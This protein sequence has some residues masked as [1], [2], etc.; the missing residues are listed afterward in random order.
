MFSKLYNNKG[1]I[2]IIHIQNATLAGG[3]AIGA[4]ADL[5]IHPS[6][7]ITVGIIA[8]FVS[9]I[10]YVKIEPYLEFYFESKEA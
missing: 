6:G 7:A 8:A 9:V 5:Y 3:I 10:G 1:K 2:D 4:A